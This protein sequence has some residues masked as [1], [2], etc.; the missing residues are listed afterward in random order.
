MIKKIIA[1]ILFV[2]AQS[3]YADM[4]G[5]LAKTSNQD[6]INE[7]G[8]RLLY[9]PFPNPAEQIDMRASFTCSDKMKVVMDLTNTTNGEN[10]QTIIPMAIW[11]RCH[12]TADTLNE[13][14]G[15]QNSIGK[16][17]AICGDSM[18][19][20]KLLISKVGKVSVTKTSMSTWDNCFSAAD[21]I[22]N[23]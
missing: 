10:S 20:Y 5:C 22:N 6:L 19:L 1:S 14:I 7:L 12:Q 4:Q 13:K 16:L 2:C 17:F 21:K 3:S 15:F 8:R 18:I 23:Q 11:D 9:Q